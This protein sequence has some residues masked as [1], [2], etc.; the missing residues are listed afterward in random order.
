[1]SVREVI[2]FKKTAV[3]ID[4]EKPDHDAN[5]CHT[6]F[7]TALPDNHQQ[8]NYTYTSA[9]GR[10]SKSERRLHDS[11][12][13]KGLPGGKF[14]NMRISSL[15]W[16]TL[17]IVGSLSTYGCGIDTAQV[18]EAN[19]IPVVAT[20]L[21]RSYTAN[22]GLV[23]GWGDHA[24]PLRNQEASMDPIIVEARKFYDT[25]QSPNA[26]DQL[27]DYPDPF[28]GAPA[29]PKKTA[30]LTLDAWKKAFNV[31]PRNQGESLA[32][33]R[34][35]SGAV[36]YYNKNE[37]GLGRELGCG[38]FDDGTDADGKPLKGIGCYVSNY[39]TMFRDTNNSLRLAAE[40]LH[41]KNTV[42]IT[43]RPSLGAGYEVQFYVY[44]QDNVRRE[45]AQLDTLGPRPAPQVCMN[46]HGGAY[47][48]EKHLAKF[49]RFLPM[50][51]NV[52]VFPET[53]GI[54][55]ADQEERIRVIN[56]LGTRSPLTPAQREMLDLLYDG[57]ITVPGTKSAKS[58]F[59]LAWNDTDAHRDLFDQVIKPNCETCHLAMQTGP[60]GQ[61]LSIYDLFKAPSS[62][63]DAGLENVVCGSFAM[64][65]SQATRLNFWEMKPEAL[66]LTDGSAFDSPADVL[67]KAMGT[68][69]HKCQQLNELAN[70]NRGLSPDDL[71]GNN[72]SGQACNRVTGRCFPDL[73]PYAPTDRSQ[74]N[75]VCKLNGTRGCPYPEVCQ[76]RPAGDKIPDGIEG[77]DGVCLPD[78]QK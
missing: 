74:P 49:A 3:L 22:E 17:P 1:V 67:L 38:V 76:P 28:T 18:T 53:P 9:G 48:S 42:C 54:T 62:L 43:Y 75:G 8:L 77:F 59:P 36:V 66:M 56:E 35:R 12:E 2:G 25:V 41:Y 24:W 50:D 32:D 13:M 73:G 63:M 4:I 52:V 6:L 68:D 31:L 23:K 55:R 64:P 5:I 57:K 21:Q 60:S 47:D 39:G 34:I 30:P 70:C 7:I 71:C 14:M 72:F 40:G 44:N 69:R 61:T 51:P 78:A 15:L 29:A 16:I 37:L 26:E 11:G 10:Q 27:V 20:A 33:Y 58:W 46:C 19:P 65:N 45:W